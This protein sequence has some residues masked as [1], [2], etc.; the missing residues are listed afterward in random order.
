MNEPLITVVSDRREWSRFKTEPFT[1]YAA[2]WDGEGTETL[3]E[4]RDESLGGLCLRL[5]ADANLD[6]GRRVRI[7]YA[8]EVMVAIVRHVRPQRDGT[9]LAGFECHRA[10]E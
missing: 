1:H 7:A 9:V 8:G 2:L 10:Q 6:V 3:A 5:T 4:V